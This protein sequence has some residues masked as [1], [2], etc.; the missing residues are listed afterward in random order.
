MIVTEE[1][2]QFDISLVSKRIKAFPD[3]LLDIYLDCI[4]EEKKRREAENAESEASK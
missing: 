3:H 2:R 4:I 1:L